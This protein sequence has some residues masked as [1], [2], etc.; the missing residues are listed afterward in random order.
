MLRSEMIETSDEHNFIPF[1]LLESRLRSPR[2]GVGRRLTI[3]N[4]SR[5]RI[6]LAAGRFSLIKA[7]RR[8]YLI[9]SD[10]AALANT[11]QHILLQY[12]QNRRLLAREGGGVRERYI[13][14]FGH[15]ALAL[16]TSAERE[17]EPRGQRTLRPPCV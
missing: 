10:G 9:Q 4:R 5:A 15:A 16:I 17:R 3:N 2:C 14:H 13:I 12:K 6:R 8:D 1:L 11:A 7:Q